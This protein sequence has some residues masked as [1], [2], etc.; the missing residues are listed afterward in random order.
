MNPAVCAGLFS[1]DSG[2]LPSTIAH[3]KPELGG[4]ILTMCQ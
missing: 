3:G 2:E 1:S 4:G